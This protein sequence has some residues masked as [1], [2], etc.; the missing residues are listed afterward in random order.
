VDFETALE[1][2]QDL[3]GPVDEG[4]LAVKTALPEE[5]VGEL[6]KIRRRARSMHSAKV[7]LSKSGLDLGRS[8]P[9]PKD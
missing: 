6:P 4:R 9:L 3:A 8:A 2:R 5:L 1:Q 7:Y